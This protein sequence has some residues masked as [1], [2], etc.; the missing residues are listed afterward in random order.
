MASRTRPFIETSVRFATYFVCP[1]PSTAASRPAISLSFQNGNQILLQR[2]A[3]RGMCQGALS[4]SVEDATRG[5]SDP[6]QP[7]REHR[8]GR[9][10]APDGLTFVE[11]DRPI[12]PVS[13]RCWWVNGA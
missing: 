10:R 1:V 4:R 8:V 6:L 12:A 11:L 5:K 3:T 7:R 2:R 9:Q 13:I